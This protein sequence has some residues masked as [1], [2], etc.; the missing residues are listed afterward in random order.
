[1][2]ELDVRIGGK[3]PEVGLYNTGAEL[4]CIS[5][6]TAREL[7]LPFNPDLKLTMCDANRGL[8]MTFGVMENLEINIGGISIM[9]HAWIIENTPYQLLLGHPFQ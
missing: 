3:H 9:V 1:I 2:M 6:V 4:V 5:M 8:K 7:H